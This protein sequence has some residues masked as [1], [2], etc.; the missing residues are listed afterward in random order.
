M[1]KILDLFT[2]VIL[3]A[4][5]AAEQAP[6]KPVSGAALP[7]GNGNCR[8]HTTN[9]I[10]SSA[11]K[12][13]LD[14]PQNTH[15]GAVKLVNVVPESRTLALQ[16]PVQGKCPVYSEECTASMGTST[17]VSPFSSSIKDSLAYSRRPS[18][19]SAGSDASG[20]STAECCSP[21]AC[22]CDES[23]ERSSLEGVS[24]AFHGKSAEATRWEEAADLGEK[25]TGVQQQGACS[26]QPVKVVI[27]LTM[28][29]ADSDRGAAMLDM[30]EGEFF[31]MVRGVRWNKNSTQRR[32]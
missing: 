5:R 26:V 20:A 12:G 14:D 28:C 24:A 31:S 3:D 9:E 10:E 16:C 8:L 13:R 19:P 21:D 7:A 2:N 23:R 30:I 27:D 15:G 6:R 11:A 18:S 32:R 22:T 17:H 25:L 4:A 29:D 1:H